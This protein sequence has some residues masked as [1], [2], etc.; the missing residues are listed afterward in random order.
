MDIDSMN[1]IYNV[2]LTHKGPKDRWRIQVTMNVAAVD[3]LTACEAA[4]SELWARNTK[5]DHETTDVRVVHCDEKGF[6]DVIVT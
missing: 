3:L 1:R 4:V 5:L 6:L 2:T